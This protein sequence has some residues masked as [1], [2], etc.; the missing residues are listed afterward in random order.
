MFWLKNIYQ[1]LEQTFS[2]KNTIDT[3][4]W[5]VITAWLTGFHRNA[6]YGAEINRNPIVYIGDLIFEIGARAVR[7]VI[8]TWGNSHLNKS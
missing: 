1:F 7:H 3:N 5:N 2:W 4:P 8:R 6:F